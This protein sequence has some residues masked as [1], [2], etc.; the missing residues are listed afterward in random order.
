MKGCKLQ[1]TSSSEMPS[2][3]SPCGSAGA[4]TATTGGLRCLRSPGL[5]A[6][7]HKTLDGC[8]Q[9]LHCIAALV[10]AVRQERQRKERGNLQES[11][12]WGQKLII[13]Q[14]QFFC[15]DVFFLLQGQQVEAVYLEDHI[16]AIFLSQAEKGLEA[17]SPSFPAAVPV[18]LLAVL[19]QW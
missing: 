9:G 17:T 18:T 13:Q 8:M 2:S 12:F 5:A 11:F 1:D 19:E 6:V 3:A 16:S 4:F 10:P 7:E 14:T 15:S